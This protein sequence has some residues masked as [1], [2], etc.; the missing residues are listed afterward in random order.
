[1]AYQDLRYNEVRQTSSH[2]AFQRSEGIY[3]QVVYWRI[4]SL[5]IDLHRGKP[6]RDA[7]KKDWYIYHVAGIDPNTTVDRLSGFLQICSGIQRAIPRHEVIT[8][9]LDIKDRFHKR[10]DAS[11]SGAVL[12]GLLI[13]ALGEDHIYRPRDL[14]TRQPGATSLQ[15]A[16]AAQ[17]WPTL[18]ELRG[19]F[20]FVLTGSTKNLATYAS[21]GKANGRAAFL[22]TAIS[23]AREV[24]GPGHI[25][26][27]NMSGENVRFS[28]NVHQAG[29]VSRTYYVDDKERFRSAI[30]HNCHHIATDHLNTHVDPWSRTRRSTGFPFQA[31]QGYTPS[32]TEAGEVCGVWARSGDIWGKRDSFLYHYRD[33]SDHMDNQHTL[34]ISGPNSRVEDWVKGGVIARSSLAR[35]SPY[36][37]VF[38][39]GEHH[40]LRIQYRVASRGPTMSAEKRLSTEGLFDADTLLYVKLTISRKGHRARAWGSVDGHDWTELGFYEFPEPLKYQGIGVSSHGVARGAKFLFGVPHD[41]PRPRFNHTRLIGKRGAGDKGWV[42]WDGKRRWRV[43]RFAD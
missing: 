38:R 36:F 23:K 4:R 43:N 30:D 3:D 19:K 39:V 11:Q 28:R 17:G 8:V 27:Y 14:L 18:E 29:L 35:S 33:Y 6:F 15:K 41:R 9:F 10:A 34:Y 31:L 22:S 25:V 5:E 1:M 7:L 32:V 16:V 20:L 2:N 40:G 37:G 24:P 13:D 21:A 26:F 12:D 42:D